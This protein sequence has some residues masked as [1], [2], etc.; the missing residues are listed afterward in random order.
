[1][2]IDKMIGRVFRITT[3]RLMLAVLVFGAS[4]IDATAQRPTRNSDRTTRRDARTARRAA[5]A[6]VFTNPVLAGDYPDPSV[7]R[8][9]PDYYATATSS[10]WAPEFPLM[11]SRDLVN[12][13][14]IGAVFQR[15]PAW[16]IGD[17]WAPEI[18]EDR[19]RFYIYYVARQRPQSGEQNG[20]LCV[21]VATSAR[22]TGPYTDRGPLICKDAGSIDGFPIRDEQGR[23]YLVWKYDGNSQNKKTPIHAQR[24]SE[25]GTRLTGEMHTLIT[26]DA[27]WE[28]NLV[29]GS[30]ITRRGKYFYMFYSGNACCTNTCNYAMGVA[31]AEKLLGPWE[32]YSGNPIL[33]GNDEWKCP[34]HGTIVRDARGRDQMLYHAYDAE[35]FTYVGRQALLDEVEWTTDGWAR[36]NRGR[37]PSG[38]APAPFGIAERNREYTFADEFTAR[39]LRP[40]WQWQQDSEPTITITPARGGRLTLAPERARAT[41]M[42]GGVLG[43]WT[44][45]G[46]YTAIARLDLRSIPAGAYAGIGAFGDIDN[47]LGVVVNSDNRVMLYRREKKNHVTQAE[48]PL[49]AGRGNILH[50]RM[51]VRDGHL[52]RFAVSRDGVNYEPVGTELDGAYMPPWDRGI[53]VVLTSGGTP[54]ARATFE[55]AR[56][57]ATPQGAASQAARSN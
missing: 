33:A 30:Y 18:S 16:A 28:G 45:A 31:R 53:R 29:E 19:G 41:D 3:S 34:G 55:S 57:V 25:D 15:R 24:L 5:R 1:M 23:K 13:D 40:G 9:G 35:D 44:T 52:Y 14:V 26:N 47:A 36:I 2:F 46:D 38:V 6:A 27:A 17:F 43:W 7:I 56:I 42:I 21:A 20:R 54:T 4:A 51:T 8:V 49:P 12:W 11:H 39:T 22:P 50:L 48:A 32:K 37:G 10:A